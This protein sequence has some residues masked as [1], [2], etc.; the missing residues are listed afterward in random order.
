[1]Y[2]YK[3]YIKAYKKI[4]VKGRMVPR[5]IKKGKKSIFL[6]QL[7]IVYVYKV[8]I[9]V[10]TFSTLKINLKYRFLYLTKKVFWLFLLITNVGNSK[11]SQTGFITI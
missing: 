6:P 4:L 3:L 2:A 10:F 11:I 1:M 7:S 8:I 5:T 9:P